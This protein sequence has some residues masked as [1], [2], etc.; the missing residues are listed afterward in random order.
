M[1]ALQSIKNAASLSDLA[2]LLNFTP[3]GL[4]YLLYKL[5]E[6]EKY[7]EFT[8][9]KK[10]GG[11]RQIQSPHPWLKLLQSRLAKLLYDCLDELESA[12]SARRN[13]S[14][15]FHRKR[16]TITNAIPHRKRRYVLNVDLKDFFGSFNFGRVRGFFI[17]DHSF[18][19]DASV[20]TVIAQIVCHENGLPQGA[21]SSPIIANLLG[22]ILDARLR[23]FAE[24]NYC[25]Y[26]RYADD[27]SFSTHL[28]KFPHKI[29][30]QNAKK[31]S[32]WRLS[33]EF[34]A[35]IKGAGF[36]INHKKTR[37]QIKGS[38]QTVTGLVVNEKI[39]VSQSYYRS[40]RSMCHNLF[41]NGWYHLGLPAN[42]GFAEFTAVESLA[43]LEGRLSHLFY[44]KAR[45]DRD[46][47]IN[48]RED[49]R[50]PKAVR[51]LYRRFLFFK[52][53]VAS[54][55]PVIVTEGKTDVVYLKSAIK[56]IEDSYPYL[57]E[58]NDGKKAL[59]VQF[60]RPSRIN[61]SVLEI[62][63]SSSQIASLIGSY[64]NRL[65]PYKHKPL[66]HPVILVVDDDDGING[67]LKAAKKLTKID[68]GSSA[69]NCMVH[70]VHNLYL[71]KTPPIDGKEK[72]CM[73]DFFPDLLKSKMVGGKSFNQNKENGDHT[74]YGKAI[75]AEQVVAALAKASDF[76]GF[77]PILYSINAAISH[78]YALKQEESEGAEQ[79]N[80]TV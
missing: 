70:L 45:R 59:K 48:K 22:H 37:M 26:T 44:V 54:S 49:F 41:V 30:R 18:A 9:P 66:A 15:G 24:A 76:A 61:N 68:I 13:T 17:H 60:L 27:L 5:P 16:G 38:R 74:A 4:S 31:P 65:K 39:N 32:V 42:E 58:D 25:Y 43:P 78:Y 55:A 64:S 36:E 47:A 52:Y 14:H 56:K 8:I 75:F 53:F 19:L 67:V 63:S 79:E 20:A 62:G 28:R 10:S 80:S 73:E 40:V 33:S 34:K 23:K 21:P 7:T 77:S 35:E 2:A 11:Q 51:E 12:D 1:S 57:A 29:A 69:D 72:T 46:E 50:A 3:S 6:A 71:V